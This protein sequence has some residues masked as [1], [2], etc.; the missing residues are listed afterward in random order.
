MHSISRVA[1]WLLILMLGAAAC[2]PLAAP[3]PISNQATVD[4]AVKAT[5]TAQSIF[6][7][8]TAIAQ[9]ASATPTTTPTETGLPTSTAIPSMTPQTLPTLTPAAP[10][11][12]VSVATNCRSGPARSH[13]WLGGLYPGQS[14]RVVG[15]YPDLNYWIIENPSGGG[16]CWLWGGYAT[17]TGDTSGLPVWTAPAQPAM[18]SLTVSVKTACRSAPNDSYS[19]VGT[20]NVGEKAEIAGR[21]SGTDWWLIVNPDAAGTCWIPGQNATISG[22]LHSLP[23]VPTP[24]GVPTATPG[25]AR[26]STPVSGAPQGYK[27]SLVEFSPKVGDNFLPKG[28]FDGRWKVKNTGD[29]AWEIGEVDYRYLSGTKM[30]KRGSAFD[31]PDTIE[32]GDTLT[33]VVDMIAPA[34]L[35]RYTTTWGLVLNS[36]TFCSL[37]LTID[38]T[39]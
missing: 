26:T 16:T 21:S 25:P 15:K 34:E 23:F 7:T 4:A 18:P 37:P 19:E 27:C 17:V 30:Y 20:L 11:V 14:A 36:K 5:L 38:V 32:P 24:Q 33:I 2:V 12:S 9:P 8:A 29:E 1:I 3:A 6:D 35:G 13:D 39:K 10:T 31:L 28:E 22:N